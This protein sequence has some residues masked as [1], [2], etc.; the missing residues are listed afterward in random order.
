MAKRVI[1]IMEYNILSGFCDIQFDGTYNLNE[2]RKNLCV[3]VVKKY[4]PDIL[5][6]CEADFSPKNHRKYKILNNYAKIFGYPYAYYAPRKKRGGGAI[7][8]KFPIKSENYSIEKFSFFRSIL[9]LGK[10][11]II[12]DIFHPHPYNPDKDKKNFVKSILRDK[13][14]PYLLIGD[15]NAIS[16]KDKYNRKR[17]I[18]GFN[19]IVDE[20]EDEEYVVDSILKA[21][22]I[23]EV[24]K[25]GLIDTYREKNKSGKLAYTN[26]TNF[27]KGYEKSQMRIDFIFCSKDFK[28]LKSGIIKNFK[29]D[30]ISDHYPIYADLELDI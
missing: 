4:N 9:K 7:L 28:V 25:S 1:K 18:K 27:E 17:L 13:N 11:E 21:E 30:K 23:S 12:I 5:I 3:E 22:T 15:F 14:N 10:K 26:P 2:K 8:S 19:K 6:L 29:T 20:D 16:P 24:L